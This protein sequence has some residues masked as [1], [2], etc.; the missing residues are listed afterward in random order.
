MWNNK[1]WKLCVNVA[2]HCSYQVAD[3]EI[4]AFKSLCVADPLVL[5]DVIYCM[6]KKQ[7]TNSASNIESDKEA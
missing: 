7:A 4:S 1:N 6:L 2:S 3:E 5:Q